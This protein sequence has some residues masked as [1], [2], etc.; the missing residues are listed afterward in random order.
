MSAGAL[1]EYLQ[2][3]Q[4]TSQINQETLEKILDKISIIEA[5]TKEKNI[6]LIG[7]YNI[8]DLIEMLGISSGTIYSR[9]KKDIF[10]HQV[11][12]GQRTSG[13]CKKEI[14]SWI[15]INTNQGREYILNKKWSNI[16]TERYAKKNKI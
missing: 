10:P 3:E 9:I 2:Q 15:E 1:I 4:Q 7:Y 6:N 12:L 11:K 14:A 8:D 5:Q 16:Y 13:W